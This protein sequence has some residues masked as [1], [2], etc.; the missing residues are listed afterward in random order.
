[1]NE[2]GNF[3][4]GKLLHF[5]GGLFRE[6]VALSLDEEGLKRLLEAAKCNWADVEPAIFGTLIERALDPRERHA[7]GAHYTPR[8]YVERLVRPT[9]EEPLRADWDVVQ[10]E[11]R[12]L[13]AAGKEEAAKKAVRA[14]HQK[15]CSLRVLDPACGSG[16]FLYVSLDLFKR[17]EGEVLGML[18]GLG[19]T[20]KLLHMETVRD[21]AQFLGIEIKPWAKEIAELVLWIGYL[22]WHFK[23]YGKSLPSPSPSCRTTRT[24]NA[25]MRCWPM[26]A[27]SWCLMTRPSRSRNGMALRSRKAPLPGRISPMRRPRGHFIAT[28]TPAG[29]SGHKRISSLAIRHT[30]ETSE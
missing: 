9:I 22:Q 28:R 26:T 20:Q 12:Q 25:A 2:G 10:A 30:S 14:F 18:A 7:L 24:S 3:L 17:L 4:V 21:P 8:A 23:T 5:N 13:V 6:P 27:S 15:L 29:Q 1:M 16:N 19:E 11:V